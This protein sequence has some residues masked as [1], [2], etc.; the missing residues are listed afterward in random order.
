MCVWV[1]IWVCDGGFTDHCTTHYKIISIWMKSMAAFKPCRETEKALTASWAFR[2]Q[3]HRVLETRAS[4]FPHAEIQ[5]CF[6]FFF[7]Q[8]LKPQAMGLL[9]TL[10]LHTKTAVPLPFTQTQ[11]PPTRLSATWAAPRFPFKHLGTYSE[12]LKACCL[13]SLALWMLSNS[14][15]IV[16]CRIVT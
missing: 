1:A 5:P 14:Q 4:P 15:E 10:F 3:M 16:K 7:C 9:W 12:Q 2:T 13:Y 6:F 8:R 11:A